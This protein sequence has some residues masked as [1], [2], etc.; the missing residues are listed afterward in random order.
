[1]VGIGERG[2]GLMGKAK[3]G[4]GERQLGYGPVENIWCARQFSWA[5]VIRPGPG[6]QTNQEVKVTWSEH[7]ICRTPPGVVW[8]GPVSFYK[9][10]KK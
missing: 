2:F 5:R 3:Q 6:Q 9:K 4:D 7:R 8:A 1:M 10:F